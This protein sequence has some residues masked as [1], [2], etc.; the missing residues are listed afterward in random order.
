[1]RTCDRCDEP[2]VK[3]AIHQGADY[4]KQYLCYVHAVERGLTSF[5]MEAVEEAAD[6]CGY[7]IH[8]V[9]FVAEALVRA[10]GA[11][12]APDVLFAALRS[13]KERF[14]ESAGE[15]LKR[16]RLLSRD[17]LGEIY[18]A[19]QDAEVVPGLKKFAAQDFARDL[20]LED[21]L[22]AL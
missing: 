1:M 13:A 21:L 11:G 9:M 2:A 3:V 16:W 14:G 12:S 17:S 7:P 5:P 8:G 20:T 18:L 6:R 22:E 15:V 10:E 4:E 19:L